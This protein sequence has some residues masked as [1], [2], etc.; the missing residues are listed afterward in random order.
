[1]RSLIKEIKPN[2]ANFDYI[3]KKGKINGSLLIDIEKVIK[4]VSIK[5][6]VW[7]SVNCTPSFSKDGWYVYKG[8]WKTTD[9]CFEI[10]IHSKEADV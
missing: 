1:M 5:F 9:E 3:K 6:G 2:E 4:I 7:L 10:F 8:N